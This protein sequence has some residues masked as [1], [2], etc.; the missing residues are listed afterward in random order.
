MILALTPLKLGFYSFRGACSLETRGM[1]WIRSPVV[2][3][4]S[5]FQAV[6]YQVTYMHITVSLIPGGVLPY[7]GYT[8]MC[9][10]E[11]YSFQ[12]VYSRIGYI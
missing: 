7:M 10:C 12:A 4:R 8:G 2:T 3:S 9:R 11:G 1:S 6:G 5:L